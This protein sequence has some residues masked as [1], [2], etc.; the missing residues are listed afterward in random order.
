MSSKPVD[1]SVLK[2]DFT[3]RTASIKVN[4]NTYDR[5]IGETF[6]SYFKLIGVTKNNCAYVQYGDVALPMCVGQPLTLQ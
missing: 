5:S 1:V 6:A 4:R 3:K 2:V